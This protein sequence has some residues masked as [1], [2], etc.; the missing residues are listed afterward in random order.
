MS[1]KLS[2]N[3]FKLTT[4]PSIKAFAA[5]VGKKE[6]EGPLAQHFDMVH[7]DTTLGEKTWEKAESRLQKDAVNSA[8]NKAKLAPSD[9]DLLFAGD[10]LNQCIGTSFGLRELNIPMYGLYGACSTM[11]EGLGLA[12][13]FADNKLVENAVAVTSSHFCSAERQFRFPLEYGGQ[14]TPTAQ[15]TVTGSGCAV[16]SQCDQPPYIKGVTTG[17]IQDLGI[18]DINNMGAAMAPAA[19]YTIKQYLTDT[20]T[21]P[22]DYDLIL[23]G[24]LGLVGSKLLVE[25]LKRDEIDIS[26]N[27]NDC[28]KLIFNIEEQ[29]VHAGGSG[30]GCSASVLC[31]YILKR[32]QE[33]VLKDILF[34][35]TGALMSPTSMQQGESIPSIAHLVHIGNQKWE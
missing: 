3:T 19:E 29:D 22:S 34:V 31:S 7:D 16:V 8:L 28:G 25:L 30:C 13:I 12:A 14:R 2:H 9:I 17:K 35:A 21:K 1:V 26:S 15:W 11:A 5:V 10:L 27:H 6:G 20:N 33:G 23:T 32:V 18:K 4:C 24:D